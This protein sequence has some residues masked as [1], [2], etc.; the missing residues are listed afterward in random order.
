MK[1]INIT[2]KLNEIGLVKKEQAFYLAALNMGGAT[3]SSVAAS[4]GIS[5]TNGY[6]ILE[7]LEQRGLLSMIPD[8]DGTKKV[9]PEDPAVLTRD[10]ERKRSILNELVPE[11]RS[12]YNN[13]PYI[14][15]TRLYEGKEGIKRA[16]WET[17][18]C[19]S[20]TLL[21]ILS[22]NELFE[23]PGQEWMEKFIEERT[24]RA[25]KLKVIRSKIRENDKELWTQNEA[26]LRELKY[27]PENIDLGMTMYINDE[28]VTYVSSV[29]ENYA[30]VVESREL[31]N[32]NR[33]LF[34]SLWLNSSHS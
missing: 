19:Q 15:R 29:K 16:L 31:S 13:Q 30:M 6:D 27:A 4:A 24:R 22:M 26:E 14:P 1:N 18:Q 5:R 3:V 23:T 21:G 12:I 8:H 10:W 32:L 33:A 34:K 7:R 28:K 11:L 20:K 9:Y 17:L 2:D 25:I